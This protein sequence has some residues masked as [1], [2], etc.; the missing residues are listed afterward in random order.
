MNKNNPYKIAERVNKRIKKLEKSS[1]LPKEKK[2][3]F[4]EFIEVLKSDSNW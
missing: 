1:K 4:L 3:N 2:K